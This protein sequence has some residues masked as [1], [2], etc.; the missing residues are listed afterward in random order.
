V[1]TESR[2]DIRAVE[3]SLALLWQDDTAA[4]PK[5]GTVRACSANLIMLIAPE[6]YGRWQLE[7]AAISRRVPSRIL[8]LEKAPPGSQPD[9]D[10]HVSATCHRKKGGDLVCS[11]VIHIHAVP[12]T[13]QRLASICRALTV[14]DLDVFLLL[15]EHLEVRPGT[16][17]LLCDL[18]DLVI[19]DSARV[20]LGL[21][22]REHVCKVADLVWPRITPWRSALGH[23]LTTCEL[24]HTDRLDRVEMVGDPAVAR[25]YAGWLAHLLGWRV[26]TESDGPA[27][28]TAGGEPVEFAIRSADGIVTGLKEVSLSSGLESGPRVRVSSEDSSGLLI[29]AEVEGASIRSRTSVP[30]P[31]LADEVTRLVHTHGTDPVYRRAHALAQR[32]FPP[33]PGRP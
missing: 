9:I 31:D 27:A 28:V 7:I 10:A 8:L 21:L 17:Q 32:M 24:I 13:V 33:G 1:K 30:A 16:V 20:G 4:G 23:F 6:S 29:E 25:I 3:D 18:S 22:P 12:G 26:E 5:P 19:V 2:F 15:L 11:E 14:S